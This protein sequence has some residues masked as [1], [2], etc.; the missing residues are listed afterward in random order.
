MSI[1]LFFLLGNVG[2]LSLCVVNRTK[3]LLYTLVR[4]FEFDLAISAKDIGTKP[5]NG[6]QRPIILTD[7][8]SSNQMPLL[9]RPV[10]NV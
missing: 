9:V 5:H 4:A 10:S 2:V 7:P 8:N 1:V 6:S 3:A